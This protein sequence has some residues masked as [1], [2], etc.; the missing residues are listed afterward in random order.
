MQITE[1]YKLIVSAK[2]CPYC[3][4]EPIFVD[5]SVIYGKSYGMIYF[6][7]DCDAYCGV[8]KDTNVPLGRL[9]N[10]TLRELKKEA[11]KY[12]DEIWKSKKMNRSEAYKWLSEKLNLP[13][14]YTHIGMFNEDLCKNTRTYCYM[15]LNNL[16]L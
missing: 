9:A 12:F 2:I 6:C 7:K 8:H 14:E 5:S 1:E 13:I 15:Y 16:T 10:K 3:K 11:H 4:Q